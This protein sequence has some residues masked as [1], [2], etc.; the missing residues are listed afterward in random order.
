MPLSLVNQLL[1]YWPFGTVMC[2][3]WLATDVLF[4]TASILNL[5]LI[6]LDRY[7]SITKPMTY[8]RQRT[9]KRVLVMITAVWASSMV[10]CFPPLAGWKRPQRV[11]K[12]GQECS[13]TQDIGYILY[14]T[15]GSFYI[16]LIVMIIVYFKI[17]L[18]AR[19]RARRALKKKKQQQ[20]QSTQ[21][22][23]IELKLKNDEM[24]LQVP[25]VST[26][27]SSPSAN[28]S[29]AR[30]VIKMVSSNYS[31]ESSKLLVS[32]S[33]SACDSPGINKIVSINPSQHPISEESDLPVKQNS[34]T[35]LEK[36]SICVDLDE[37]S[38]ESIT[39]KN[40]KNE[41][42][43]NKIKTVFRKKKEKKKINDDEVVRNFIDDPEKAKKKLARARERRA[44][45]VLGILLLL[46]APNKKVDI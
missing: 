25:P 16:P 17:Y 14:S 21:I 1:G 34:K 9:K 10:I 12:Y 8:V 7:W 23:K 4:S 38:T 2:D 39:K 18:A 30:E 37:L 15:L 20:R 6:S 43:L 41:S 29:E 33:D 44:I 5:V 13:L 11:T 32:D 40:E 45:V 28:D 3:L 35:L 46:K 19:A 22:T 31:H 24:R 27:L 36:N 42:S 26:D